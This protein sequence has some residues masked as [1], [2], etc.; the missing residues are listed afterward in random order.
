MLDDSSQPSMHMRI[1][2][3]SK[4]RNV[5]FEEAPD[6][7]VEVCGTN[8]EVDV[9]S[10]LVLYQRAGWKEYV[11]GETLVKRI[12]WRILEQTSHRLKEPDSDGIRRSVTFPGLLLEVAALW[13]RNS[14]ALSQCLDRGVATPE[15][16]TL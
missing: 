4:V 15:H 13:S 5:L 2:W 8:T 10:K 14:R 12:Q 1:L 9:R 16:A 11:T 3:R 6:L 7:A